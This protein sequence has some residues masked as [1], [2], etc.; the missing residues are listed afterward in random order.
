MA[1][2]K[3]KNKECLQKAAGG[4]VLRQLNQRLNTPTSTDDIKRVRTKP[5]PIL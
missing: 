4:G 3:I 5:N 1:K 2:K